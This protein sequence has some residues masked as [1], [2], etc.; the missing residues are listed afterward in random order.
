MSSKNGIS[1]TSRNAK[2]L[3]NEINYWKKQ[4]NNRKCTNYAE[5]SYWEIL[6]T[7]TAL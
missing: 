3:R 5:M 1:S 7:N 4:K 6:S 2:N